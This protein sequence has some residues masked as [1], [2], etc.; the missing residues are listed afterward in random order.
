MSHLS[1]KSDDNQL[2]QY[3]RND[4][5]PAFTLLFDRYYKNLVLFGGNFINEKET[6][7]DIAQSIFLKLWSERK[8]LEITS[9]LK[10]FLL[11]SVKNKCFDI[12]RHKQIIRQH[13]SNAEKFGLFFDNMDTENFVMHSDLQVNLDNILNNL[14]KNQ[15]DAF[16]MSRFEGL[17][18]KEI[19]EKLN[20]PE[21]TVV[22]LIC[23]TL[24]VLR[25]NLKEFLTVLVLLMFTNN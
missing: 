2:L 1:S 21:R 8:E 24:R 12:H 22:T 4:S 16:N 17:K 25:E 13:E 5:E 18:Y 15:Q 10:S 11:Q 19:A 9:S 20:L 14:P 23:N 6:C 7:E 3:L